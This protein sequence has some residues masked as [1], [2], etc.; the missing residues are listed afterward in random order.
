MTLDKVRTGKERV[1][2]EESIG[3]R[4]YSYRKH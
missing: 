4:H 1:E 2:A 3:G